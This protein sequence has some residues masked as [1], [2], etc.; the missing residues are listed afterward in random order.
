MSCA[1]RARPAPAPGYP[2]SRPARVGD[3]VFAT[4]LTAVNTPSRGLVSG[5]RRALP[6][7]MAFCRHATSI[8]YRPGPLRHT[9]RAQYGVIA[10]GQAMACGLTVAAGLAARPPQ[11]PVSYQRSSTARPRS[12]TMI[13]LSERHC[14]GP[15]QPAVVPAAV[16][17]ARP[18]LRPGTDAVRGGQPPGPPAARRGAATVPAARRACGPGEPRPGDPP[19]P[20]AARGGADRST[21]RSPG[22]AARDSLGRLRHAAVTRAR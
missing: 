14:P 4:V 1:R 9:L 22:P 11:H 19:G 8:S 5:L 12:T 13:N 10:R 3:G 21:G 16:P 15:P 7:R 6:T 18:G 20:P 2:A 17:A